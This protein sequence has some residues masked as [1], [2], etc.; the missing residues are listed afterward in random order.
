[1]KTIK[2][3]LNKNKNP[4]VFKMGARFEQTVFKREIHTWSR[5]IGEYFNLSSHQEVQTKTTKKH[6]FSLL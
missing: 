3:S 5:N 6:H 1:M 4:I 2:T